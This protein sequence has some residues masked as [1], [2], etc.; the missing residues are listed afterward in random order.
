MV[1]GGSSP[2]KL[3]RVEIAFILV[4]FYVL[5]RLTDEGV[6]TYGV[7]RSLAGCPSGGRCPWRRV[8]P[9]TCWG[10]TADDCCGGFA[11]AVL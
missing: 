2:I 3:D 5:N 4:L 1:P 9:P 8:S 10:G 6:Q 11:A 7:R